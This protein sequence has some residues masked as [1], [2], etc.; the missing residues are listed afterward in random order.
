MIE[1][2]PFSK[3]SDLSDCKK[4]WQNTKDAFCAR[5]RRFE[6]KKQLLVIS[7]KNQHTK[8]HVKIHSTHKQGKKNYSDDK[9][10]RDDP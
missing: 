8:T 1:K 7:Q 9:T 5:D 2:R 10:R 3:R 4:I 6:K